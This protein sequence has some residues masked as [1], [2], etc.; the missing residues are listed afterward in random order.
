MRPTNET[1][2]ASCGT[3]TAV[4]AALRPSPGVNVYR[5]TPGLTTCTMSGHASYSDTRLAPS[6]SVFAIN[7]SAVA[8][9]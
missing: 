4:R 9:T 1:T 2:N 7:A 3:A 6:A 5:S 8:T